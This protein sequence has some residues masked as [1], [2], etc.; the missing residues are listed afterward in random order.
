MQAVI[1]AAGR[2]TRMRELTE[3]I[4]KPMLLLLGKPLLEWKLNN[5]PSDISEVIITI[6]YLGEQIKE[7]FGSEWQGK[8]IIYVEQTLLNGTGGSM[9]AVEPH[10]TGP[11]LVMAGDDLHHVDDITAAVGTSVDEGFIGGLF[12]RD[13][14]L[15][16]LIGRD[17][18]G[19]LTEVIERPHNLREGFVCISL[20]MLPEK[21]FQYPLVPISETEFGLP[22]T[23]ALMANDIPVTVYSC[24]AWQPVGCPEDIPFAEDFIKKY[25]A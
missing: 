12:T 22:Q 1:L 16:G 23:V 15:F 6:G 14:E 2:G 8:K 21:Y 3:N 5:L 10:I 25:Y 18:N 19:R 4:P 7:Y 13:A 9:K 17:D 24:K 11:V 20:Y